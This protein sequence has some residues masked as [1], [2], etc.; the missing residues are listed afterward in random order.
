MDLGSKESLVK[1]R[2][3]SDPD[4]CEA[5][6]TSQQDSQHLVVTCTE[7]PTKSDHESNGS[8]FVISEEHYLVS[9]HTTIARHCLKRPLVST[10]LCSEEWWV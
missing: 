1:I 2:I 5:E 9:D 3:L 7:T 4:G 8:S 10:V 6:T